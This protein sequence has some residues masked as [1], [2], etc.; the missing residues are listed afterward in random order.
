MS[1]DDVIAEAQQRGLGPNEIETAKRQYYFGIMYYVEKNPEPDFHRF[2]S[3]T[4]GIIHHR[5]MAEYC[6]EAYARKYIRETIDRTQ[7]EVKK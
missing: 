1:L 6:G 7:K 3:A 2:R 4:L 5:K